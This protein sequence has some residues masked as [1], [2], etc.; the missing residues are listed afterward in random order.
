MQA[1]SATGTRLK[2]TTLLSRAQQEPLMIRHNRRD[3]A[4]ILSATEYQRLSRSRRSRSSSID[5]ELAAVLD[6]CD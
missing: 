3:M 4:V 6:G 5:P 2:L 1:I